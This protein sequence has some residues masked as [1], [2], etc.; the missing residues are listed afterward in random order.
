MRVLITDTVGFIGFH[1]ARLMLA[2]TDLA[3]DSLSARAP[4]RTVNIGNSDKVR[5]EDF[6]DVIEQATG[7]A[8]NRN[9]LD[10]Q[11]SD[12]PA[13]W[14]DGGLLRALTGYA[15]R[16]DIREGVAHFVEWYRGYHCD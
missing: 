9:Y 15:P 4:F 13:K 8:A 1:L 5:L 10:I 6:I 2:D 14:A 16:T 11:L 12:V 3:G 7:Q